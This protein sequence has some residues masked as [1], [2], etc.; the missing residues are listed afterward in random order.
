[1]VDLV[2]E[3]ERAGNYSVPN[4]RWLFLSLVQVYVWL[5]CPPA[6][7]SLHGKVSGRFRLQLINAS[8]P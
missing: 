4:K 6:S 2:H 3:L 8:F 7:A 1:M 5:P